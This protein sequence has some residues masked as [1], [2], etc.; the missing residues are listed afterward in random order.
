MLSFEKQPTIF[1]AANYYA[2]SMVTL[3]VKS[4]LL[5][6]FGSFLNSRLTGGDVLVELKDG[7]KFYTKRVMDLWEIKEVVIDRQ[8][9]EVRKV[10]SGDAVIDVGAGTGDFDVVADQAGAEVYAYDINPKRIALLRRNLELNGSK[11]VKAW[12]KEVTSIDALLKA[13]NLK[14]CDFLKIDCEGAEYPIFSKT[15]DKT[16]KKIDFIAMEAHLFDQPMK[17]AYRKLMD[18]LKKLGFKVT[19]FNNDVHANIRFV[20]A[21]RK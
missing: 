12:V 11:R 18:R 6:W 20:F 14:K 3:A 17:E 15:T 13:N 21:E 1:S 2:R 10:K 9:E 7:K 8:Y 5:S 16:F 19:V 4:D